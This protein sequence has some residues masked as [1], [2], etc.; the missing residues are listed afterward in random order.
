MVVY[1]YLYF[2]CRTNITNYNQLRHKRK[3]LMQM[4]KLF[5]KLYH[6]KVR[7]QIRIKNNE[8]I[9]SMQSFSN[10]PGEDAV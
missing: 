9:K 3:T 4:I 7:S 2:V 10:M 6:N 1:K 5:A 8:N